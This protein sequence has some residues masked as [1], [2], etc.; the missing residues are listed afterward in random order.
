MARKQ[1]FLK[2]IEA[3]FSD[4][5]SFRSTP[6]GIH[7]LTF[8]TK[9]EISINST[10]IRQ[11]G[12]VAYSLRAILAVQQDAM[13][14]PEKKP[15]RPL[16]AEARD[17]FKHKL[18]LAT[19]ALLQEADAYARAHNEYEIDLQNINRAWLALFK[20]KEEEAKPVNTLVSFSTDKPPLLEKIIQQKIASY[21]EYNQISNQLFIR[22][23]QV[24]F[25]RL[26]WPLDKAEAEAFRAGFIDAL[27]GYGIE[28]YKGVVDLAAKKK[29]Q[30]IQEEHLARF[31]QQFKPYYI[32]EYEDIQYFSNLPEGKVSLEA[33]DLDAFR[34]SGV[35][36]VYLGFALE[37][38]E[39]TRFLD[40][41]PFA[42]ELMAENVAQFGVLIL[43]EAGIEG[44]KI[45]EERIS[46]ELLA[47]AMQNI[48]GKVNA[49]LTG[50]STD[51][52]T[53]AEIHSSTD[54]DSPANNQSSWFT[55]ATKVAGIDSMHRSSDWL[56]RLLR[57][58]LRKDKSTGIITIPPAFGGSG[59]AVG[60]VVASY[61]VAG[62]QTLNV[63]DY[64]FEDEYDLMSIEELAEFVSSEKHLPEIANAAEINEKIDNTILPLAIGNVFIRKSASVVYKLRRP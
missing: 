50:E 58:Y 26:S 47:K 21:A 34:D 13:M 5:I 24:Y 35:H 55:D 30:V 45:G 2:K 25:A 40:V 19:L 27:V 43:R 17:L 9:A 60:D 28:L 37:S 39:I 7:V 29:N 42:A 44:A 57:S 41:D 36:W 22:N 11:Y 1:F 51:S 23:M 10:D 46:L 12:S 20:M 48:Q 62:G 31:V 59:V 63:P 16:S 64:V 18:D 32:N 14:T 3:S 52:T 4:I 33:Y 56:N 6:D 53:T 54:P 49:T 61:F 38:P 15:L 8:P